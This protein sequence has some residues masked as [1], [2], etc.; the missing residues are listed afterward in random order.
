MFY[1]TM[2]CIILIYIYT[3][4]DILRLHDVTSVYDIL[5]GKD[6]KTSKFFVS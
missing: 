5:K 1:F 3:K 6:M 4:Y 2:I